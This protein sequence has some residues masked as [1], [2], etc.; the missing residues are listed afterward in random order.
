MIHVFLKDHTKN[1]WQIML[2]HEINNEFLFDLDQ[3]TKNNI[4][5][6]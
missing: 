6:W 4:I 5:K 3:Y 1:F 2:S